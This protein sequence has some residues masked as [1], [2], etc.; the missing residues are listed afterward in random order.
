[1]TAHWGVADPAA[2]GGSE[3]DRWIAFRTAFRILEHRI[4]IFTSL[5]LSSLE[6]V[7]LQEQLDSIGQSAALES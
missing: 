1:M 7:K 4:R 2:A 6:R 5:P 3:A